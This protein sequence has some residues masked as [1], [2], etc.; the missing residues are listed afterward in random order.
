[1]K[2][3]SINMLLKKEVEV[4]RCLISQLKNLLQANQTKSFCSLGHV[5]C[6]IDHTKYNFFPPPKETKYDDLKSKSIPAL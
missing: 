4:Q 2:E 3:K 1:M 6:R 5:A